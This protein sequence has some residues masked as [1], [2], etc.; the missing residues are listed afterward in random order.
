MLELKTNLRKNIYQ[1][2]NSAHSFHR[3]FMYI[4]QL[5][6]QSNLQTTKQIQSHISHKIII[7]YVVWE[8]CDGQYSSR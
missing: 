3:S 1:T 2:G 4:I 5:Q 8:V 6:I 7:I